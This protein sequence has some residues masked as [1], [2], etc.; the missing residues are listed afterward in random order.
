MVPLLQGLRWTPGTS[1]QE[2]STLESEVCLCEGACFGPL[3]YLWLVRW[4]VWAVTGGVTPASAE[5]QVCGLSS[6]FPLLCPWTCLQRGSN[7]T[8]WKEPQYCLFLPA[9]LSPQ[10][11]ELLGLC[12]FCFKASESLV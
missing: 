6:F 5:S 1:E 4:L 11:G 2:L 10:W 9:G 12:S 7:K 8:S 3:E